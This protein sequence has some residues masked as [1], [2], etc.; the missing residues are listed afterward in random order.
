MQLL[1]DYQ[2]E[3]CYGP[4]RSSFMENSHMSSLRVASLRLIWLEVFLDVAESE[5]MSA[6]AENLCVDQSTV[7]RHLQALQRWLGKELLVATK[8][9]DPD[10]PGRNVKVTEEGWAFHEIAKSTVNNL[11]EFRT[12]RAEG[13]ELVGKMTSSMKVI[14]LDLE[15]KNPSETALRNSDIIILNNRIVN[16]LSELLNELPNKYVLNL[17][18]RQAVSQ[19]SFVMNYEVAIRDEREPARRKSN[20][21]APAPFKGT[22]PRTL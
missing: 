5:N 3:A 4:I 1:H 11:S 22:I 10:D 2:N 6:T 16:K 13:E 21:S 18:K 14:L 9:T 17:I 12:E 8:I 20:K 19:K 7:S 15:G